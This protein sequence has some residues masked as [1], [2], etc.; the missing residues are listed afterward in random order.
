MKRKMLALVPMAMVA[1]GLSTIDAGM[2][3]AKS[4]PP[5]PDRMGPPG[6][7]MMSPMLEG[8]ELTNKQREA[9]RQ[10]FKQKRDNRKDDR[11][12]ERNLH[13][14]VVD[15]LLT[16]GKVDQAKLDG[17]VQ[18]EAALR[19]KHDAERIEMDVKLHDIL[20][21]DQLSQ[22]KERHTKIT[23]LLEQLRQI[24]HPEKDD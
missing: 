13:E 18:Q 4:P 16:P 2:A 14:Q 3:Q 8:I 20:T 22:A 19:A 23:A 5:A 7:G 15:L 9:V 24:Q 11:E 21:A 17:L 12:E 1:F 10:L 6:P